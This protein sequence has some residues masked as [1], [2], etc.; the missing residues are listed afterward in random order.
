MCNPENFR[1]SISPREP[2][3]HP[4]P[5]KLLGRTP[6]RPSPPMRRPEEEEEEEESGPHSR[7]V[8]DAGVY[9][10]TAIVQVRVARVSWRVGVCSIRYLALSRQSTGKFVHVLGKW[11]GGLYF[12]II[13]VLMWKEWLVVMGWL[14]RW[15]GILGWWN[16]GGAGGG[17]F[18]LAEYLV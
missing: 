8:H 6:P 7:E 16:E 14:G 10:Q 5:R 3:T 15:M 17:G 12:S 9:I 13:V 11:I 2:I 1:I 18:L 4:I